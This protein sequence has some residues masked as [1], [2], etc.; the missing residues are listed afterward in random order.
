[1][2]IIQLTKGK[3]AI[4]DDEDYEYLSQLKW[5]FYSTGYAV[6][7]VT[8]NKKQTA[9]LLHK[10]VN[11]TQDGFVTDHIN[12]DKLDNRRCNLRSVPRSI[13]RL[14]SGLNSNNKSGWKRLFW[15]ESRKSWRVVIKIKNSELVNITLYRKSF[16]DKKQAIDALLAAE[17]I[18]L[19]EEFWQTKPELVC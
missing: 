5:S 19:P 6:R 11:Q 10:F 12:R 7:F 18:H 1:M 17:K 3:Q 2:R 14:N 15:E 16:K 13:N 9:I 4:V 8:I